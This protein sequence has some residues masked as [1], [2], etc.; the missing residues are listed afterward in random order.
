MGPLPRGAVSEPKLISFTVCP[1]V[2]RAVLALEEKGVDYDIEFIDLADKPDWF[3]E[4]SPRGKVPVL[5]DDGVPLFES[6]AI[7]EYL[8]ETRGGRRLAPED[9]KE[10]ARDRAWFTYASEE[11]FSHGWRAESARDDETLEKAI[12]TLREKMAAVENALEGREYLSGDG[13]TFGLADLAF[14]PQFYRW[15]AWRR[16]AGIDVLGDELP[17]VGAWVERLLARESVPRSVPPSWEEDA[18][19][20]GGRLGSVIARR[21]ARA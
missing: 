8:D 17:R 16:L 19:A 4:I 14:L 12:K 2:Q 13:S 9:A 3:L 21:A 5:I 15:A 7:V 1:F 20:M 10:R 11:I 6:Q 18:L